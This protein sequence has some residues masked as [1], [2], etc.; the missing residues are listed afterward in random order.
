MSDFE[1]HHSQ[2][3]WQFRCRPSL[4]S[5]LVCLGSTG[6]IAGEAGL[7]SAG[8]IAGEAG[9]GSAGFRAGDGGFGNAGFKAGEAG[10]S[11]AGGVD[12]PGAAGPPRRL[13]FL[14]PFLPLP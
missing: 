9:L 2:R 11:P 6:F 12:Q 4:S 1:P 13:P 8:F 10:F 3:L 14:L 5:P 7:G